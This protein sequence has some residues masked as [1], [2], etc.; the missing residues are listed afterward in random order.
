MLEVVTT[1]KILASGEVFT[2][3]MIHLRD[4]YAF[5]AVEYEITGDGSVALVA[6]VSIGGKNWINNGTIGSGLIKTSGAGGDGKGHLDL[7]LKPAEFLKLR[8]TVSVDSVVLTLYFV[9]K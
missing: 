7:F 9:Q 2:G 1:D 5:H 3:G 4:G 6:L 8:A